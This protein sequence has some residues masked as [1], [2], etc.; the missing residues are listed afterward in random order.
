MFSLRCVPLRGTVT[1]HSNNSISDYEV[2]QLPLLILYFT[3]RF[4]GVRTGV[5]AFDDIAGGSEASIPYGTYTRNA[6]LWDI[7]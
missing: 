2:S 4:V 1:I 5:K 7:Q 3:P 6:H